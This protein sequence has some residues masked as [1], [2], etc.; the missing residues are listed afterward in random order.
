MY[1]EEMILS[2]LGITF[3]PQAMVANPVGLDLL[4][5]VTQLST[6]RRTLTGLC[7]RLTEIASRA[8]DAAA[9]PLP[10]RLNS[11]GELQ[12]TGTAFDIA[13]ANVNAAVDKVKTLAKVYTALT[14]DRS[15]PQAM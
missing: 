8:R 2:E 12:S 11:L 7:D 14:Q 4:N 15:G 6:A 5:A 3:E 9:P 13:C 1:D 10:D